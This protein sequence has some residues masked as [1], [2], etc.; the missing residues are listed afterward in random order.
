M[1]P[2]R[3]TV[4]THLYKENFPITQIQAFGEEQDSIK[5]DTRRDYDVFE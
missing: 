1:F 2:S 4:E 5:P 3:D